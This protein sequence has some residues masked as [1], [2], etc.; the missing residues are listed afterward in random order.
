[1]FKASAFCLKLLFYKAF[2]SLEFGANP[3]SNVTNCGKIVFLDRF[4]ASK[5][6]HKSIWNEEPKPT[7]E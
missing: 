5:R 7:A 3:L 1:M 6:G 2:L 4:M